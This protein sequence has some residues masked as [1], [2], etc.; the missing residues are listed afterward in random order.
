MKSR[1]AGIVVLLALIL[2]PDGNAESAVACWRRTQDGQR[3]CLCSDSN[4]PWQRV[5]EFVCQFLMDR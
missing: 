1:I 3:V 4:H 5:G 2:A